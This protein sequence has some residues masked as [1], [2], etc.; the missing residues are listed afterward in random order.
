MATKHEISATLAERSDSAS[1]YHGKVLGM[2]AIHLILYAIE[3]YYGVTGDSK[4]LCDN[5]GALYTFKKKSKQIPAG[6]KNND[7]QRI[8]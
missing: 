3:D 2:L 5:K 4:V 1:A 6:A 8:L 7:I